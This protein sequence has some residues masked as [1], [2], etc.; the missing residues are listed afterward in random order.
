MRSRLIA[1][2]ISIIFVGLVI[3]G[4]GY[5]S[6]KLSY[7]ET[8]RSDIVRYEEIAGETST[9]M[10]ITYTPY[11][12]FNEETK[13]DFWI[14]AISANSCMYSIIDGN[15]KY[16]EGENIYFNVDGTTDYIWSTHTG[17]TSVNL[18]IVM[19]GDA[20][21]MEMDG[22]NSIYVR[23]DPGMGEVDIEIKTFSWYLMDGSSQWIYFG[24]D[25]PGDMA[26]IQTG[27]WEY[28]FV[29]DQTRLNVGHGF[30]NGFPE[31]ERGLM[32]GFKI[33]TNQYVPGHPIN[34]DLEISPEYYTVSEAITTGENETVSVY[35]PYY[36]TFSNS[37]KVH[38]YLLGTG[39]FLI[40]ITAWIAS[41]W[42]SY[43]DKVLPIN[44]YRS[45]QN[46][47]RGGAR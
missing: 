41:P 15:S 35:E 34:L 39:A 9:N 7:I 27:V 22:A 45:L 11:C 47:N 8:A 6:E 5:L 36:L 44:F 43:L 3:V 21:S 24:S 14:P 1:G 29:L 2:I 4:P 42:R 19:W 20:L 17:S 33:N 18:Y 25:Y 31:E 12:E 32:V 38:K 16:N 26:S 30:Q 10:T 28:L 40:G 37:Y 46:K 23:F 13:R